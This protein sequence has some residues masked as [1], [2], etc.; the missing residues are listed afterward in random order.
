MLFGHHRDWLAAIAGELREAVRTGEI[1]ELDV[2][3]AAFQ[4]DAVLSAANIA[5][6]TGDSGA[7][8]RVR[9]VVEAFLAGGPA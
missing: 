6:R 4:I 7:T 3:L 9:R 5:L 8:D 1:A 2:D